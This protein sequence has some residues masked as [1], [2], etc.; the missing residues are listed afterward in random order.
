[1]PLLRLLYEP[2][3]KAA[4][5]V[6]AGALLRLLPRLQ[7]SDTKR[8]RS[9]DRR[10][11]LLP[12]ENRFDPE[13]TLCM[14]KT[15]EQVGDETA[16]PLVRQLA[17]MRLYDPR[18]SQAAHE[19]LPYLTAHAEQVRQAQTLLRATDTVTTSPDDLLR[20]AHYDTD[21]EPYEELLRPDSGQ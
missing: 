8:W 10:L 9:D 2:E 1:V 4:D 18:I 16:L 6:L 21:H 15:L 7:Y 12:L 19:C 11:L 5:P 13:L 3:T 14:L 17:G 20:P